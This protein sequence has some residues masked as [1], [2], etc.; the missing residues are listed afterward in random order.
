MLSL[1]HLDTQKLEIL[2]KKQT[3]IG[4]VYGINVVNKL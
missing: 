1:L 3:K 4:T 2:F